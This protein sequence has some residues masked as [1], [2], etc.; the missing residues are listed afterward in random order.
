MPLY[1]EGNK[2][3]VSNYRPISL[4]TSFSKILEKVIQTR[5]LDRLHKNI[6]SK[7]QYRFQREFKTENAAYELI[8]E[9]LNVLNNK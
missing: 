7:E 6:I 3:D 9:V 4:V 2:R 5:L 1:K 8:N